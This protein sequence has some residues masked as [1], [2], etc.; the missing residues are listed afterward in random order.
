MQ[1]AHY[2]CISIS[3]HVKNTITYQNQIWNTGDLALL[4]AYALA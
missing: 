2:L 4:N 3:F 1:G